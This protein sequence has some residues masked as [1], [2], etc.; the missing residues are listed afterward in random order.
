[1]SLSSKIKADLDH[2]LATFPHTELLDLSSHSI[3]SFFEVTPYLNA[4]PNLNEI[5]LTCNLV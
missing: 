2:L 3:K 5:D 1:M 4:F